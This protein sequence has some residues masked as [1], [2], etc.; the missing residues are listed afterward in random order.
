MTLTELRP[1]FAR[2]IKGFKLE[3]SLDIADSYLNIAYVEVFEA[4]RWEFRK[5]TANLTLI[6]KYTTGT[7]SVTKFDG[8]NSSAAKKVTFSGATLTGMAG[9]YLR[10]QNSSNWHKIV[11]V[12][13]N[14]V[15]LDSE[16]SDID[17]ASGLTFEI[18]KR[19]NYV[20][21]DVDVI[22]D[23]DKWSGD[24][25]EY[26]PYSNLTEEPTESLPGTP[27][28]FSPYGVDPFDD[29]EYSTGTVSGS[30]DSNVLTGSTSPNTA[31]LSSGFDTGDLI[32]VGKSTFYV[33]RIESDNRIVLFNSITQKIETGT[34]YKFKKNNPLGF[35]FYNP[36]DAYRVLNYTYLSR[37]FPL[38]HPSLDRIQLSRRFIP[39]IVSRAVYYAMRD[40]QDTG[41]AQ[42]LQIYTA[43][44]EGL[45]EKVRSVEPRYTIFAPKI[46]A[47]M[48]GRGNG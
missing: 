7:C 48:P 30:Q 47:F 39:A 6:P 21:S 4:H 22:Y 42:M 10:V 44:L 20:K 34:T 5:K 35:Q 26:T 11:Y 15:Y 38:I 8:S 41:M 23:F 43:E 29:I 2:P 1:L 9:R 13:G 3:T 24:R 18:W 19:F 28:L 25:V 46:P 17:S 16:I 36:T 45:K 37:A 27:Y 40:N 31:W 32:E 14:D 33:K 12:S